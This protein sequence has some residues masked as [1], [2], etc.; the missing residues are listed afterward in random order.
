VHE[1]LGALAREHVLR[2][3]A[4]PGERMRGAYLVDA[5]DVEAFSAAVRGLQ[6]AEPSLLITCTGP[7]PPYS[8]TQP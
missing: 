7:W 5:S 6:E 4:L 3:V 1:P 2:P 8:F